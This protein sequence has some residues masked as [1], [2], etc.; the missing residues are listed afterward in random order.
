MRTEVLHKSKESRI[1]AFYVNGKLF[2]TNTY[3]LNEEGLAYK[4]ICVM[5]N[6]TVIIWE[7]GKGERKV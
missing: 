1:T 6:G 4:E 5:E 7:E 3:L 2:S